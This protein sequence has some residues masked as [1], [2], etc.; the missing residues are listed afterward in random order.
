MTNPN[1]PNQPYGQQ[2]NPQQPYGAPQGQPYPQQPYGQQPPP[3]PVKKKRKWP[4]IVL[5]LI[6]VFVII[7]VATSQGG[8]SDTSTAAPTTAG[9]SEGQAQGQNPPA[10]EETEGTTIPPL[11]PAAPS[12]DGKQI[13]Y[14]V[15]SDSPTLGNVTYFDEDSAIQQESSVAAPWSMELTNSST[16]AIV[17][18]TAQTDGTSVTCRIVVDGEIEDEQ[19]ATGQFAVVSCNAG[20]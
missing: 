2:P 16:F 17:G 9:N 4:W 14:E 6:V 11:V 3:Q 8:D 10:A 19:T 12:G 13:T 18:V 15:I 7:G 5:A 1:D 20:L